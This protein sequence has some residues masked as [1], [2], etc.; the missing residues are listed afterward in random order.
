VV[1]EGSLKPGDAHFMDFFNVVVGNAYRMV[2]GQDQVPLLSPTSNF[3]HVFRGWW[4]DNSTSAG[5]QLLAGERDPLK[6]A[7]ANWVDHSY[8]TYSL[9][10]MTIDH[11]TAPDWVMQLDN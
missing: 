6:V 4:L 8:Y 9:L 2:N 1:N 10:Q 7:D 3:D 11:A 5:P